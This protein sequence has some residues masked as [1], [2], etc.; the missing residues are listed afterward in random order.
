MFII[1]ETESGQVVKVSGSSESLFGL[2]RGDAA[3]LTGKVK[4]HAEWN[5][6]EQTVLNFVKAATVEVAA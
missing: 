1:A 5:G 2:Q 3:T 4:E 6:Q